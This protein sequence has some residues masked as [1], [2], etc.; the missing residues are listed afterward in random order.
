MGRTACEDRSRDAATSQGTPRG[1]GSPYKLEARK[2]PPS[3]P[4]EK[5]SIWTS[6]F[7]NGENRSCLK[8]PRSWHPQTLIERLIWTVTE[9]E[10]D[11]LVPLWGSSW[12]KIAAQ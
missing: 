3:G 9:T 12:H 5:A 10:E 7:Q 2:N 6:D 11:G 4:S 1:V 8:S